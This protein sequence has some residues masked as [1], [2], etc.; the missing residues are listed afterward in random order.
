MLRKIKNLGHCIY[1]SSGDKIRA[2]GNK[3]FAQEQ[4]REPRGAAVDGDGNVLVVD[5]NRC[6]QKFTADVCNH[7][8]SMFASEGQFLRSFVAKGEEPGQFDMLTGIAVYVSDFSKSFRM[9]PV[10]VD[11]YC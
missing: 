1:N 8:S 3:G 10:D 5:G 9:S 6:I 4:F 2:F 11:V 7:I